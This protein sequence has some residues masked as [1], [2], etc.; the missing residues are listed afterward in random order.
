MINYSIIRVK[1]KNMKIEKKLHYIVS[2]KEHKMRLGIL[3]N[4][5]KTTF[6]Q[7]SQIK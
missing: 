3:F 1:R 7:F 6:S 4:L 2:N 5:E